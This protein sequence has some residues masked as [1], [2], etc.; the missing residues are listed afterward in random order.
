MLSYN[1][2]NAVPFSMEIYCHL[3]YRMSL[4]RMQ[5]LHKKTRLVRLP[6]TDLQFTALIMQHGDMYVN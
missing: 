2:E 4:S 1:T 3:M 6:A 5:V